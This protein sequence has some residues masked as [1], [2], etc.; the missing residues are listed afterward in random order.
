MIGSPVGRHLRQFSPVRGREIGDGQ[1]DFCAAP[2]VERLIADARAAGEQEGLR[3]AEEEARRQLEG[4]TEDAARQ[5]AEARAEVAAEIGETLARQMADALALMQQDM[6]DA[7]GVVIGP[8][9]TGRRRQAAIDDFVG[10]VRVILEDRASKRLKLSAPA[11]MIE[12]IAERLCAPHLTIETHVSN[13]CAVVAE[14]DE[15]LVRA[16]LAPSVTRWMEPDD[17]K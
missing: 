1:G 15:T 6:F 5:V 4:L 3:R 17:A 11:E 2:D 16:A 7:I 13:D 8:L 14:I 9:Y 12:T 10:Q